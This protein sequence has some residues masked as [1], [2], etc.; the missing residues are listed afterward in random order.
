M[1]DQQPTIGR[2][3]QYRGKQGYQA[4]RAARLGLHI[5]DPVAGYGE[6]ALFGLGVAAYGALQHW[7]ETRHGT[8]G[9]AGLARAAARWMV[10][11]APAVPTYTRPVR[12]AD[13]AVRVRSG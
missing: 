5:P 12:P 11:G 3:V 2:I 6:A 8:G 10:L 9:W 7:L 1:P 13:G 4:L